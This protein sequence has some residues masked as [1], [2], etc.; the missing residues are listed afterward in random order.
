M[1]ANEHQG[2]SMAIVKHSGPQMGSGK[3]AGQLDYFLSLAVL[4]QGYSHTTA[5]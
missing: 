5:R 4:V 2:S 3:L 1:R